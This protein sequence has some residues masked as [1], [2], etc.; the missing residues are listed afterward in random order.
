MQAIDLKNKVEIKWLNFIEHKE[1][2]YKLR[3]TVF[4]EQQGID[5]LTESAR[6]ENAI[7]LGAYYNGQLVSA[8]CAY[9]YFPLDEICNQWQ[10]TVP[11]NMVGHFARRV[12]L[13]E[14]RGCRLAEFLA[15]I[16][17]KSIHEVIHPDFLMITLFDTHKKL[18]FYYS[19][20]GFDFLH[21]VSTTHGQLAIYATN[22]ESIHKGISKSRTLCELLSA[23]FETEIPPLY[24]FLSK[25]EQL[26]FFNIE[27][28]KQENLYLNPISFKDELPRLSAQ[29]RMLYT[30]QKPLIES[31]DFPV[32]PA[33]ML[34]LGCGPGIFLAMISNLP[35]F[36]DYHCMGMD[37][38]PEMIAYAKLSYKKITWKVG[39]IY[40]TG[41]AAESLD[42]I[43]SS[44]VMIHL[45]NPELALKE[46]YRILKKGG[47]FYIVD[48]N[49]STFEGHPKIK[50]MIRKHAQI[51]EGNRDIMNILPE[52]AEKQNFKFHKQLETLIENSGEEEKPEVSGNVFKL[53]RV[54]MWAIFSFIS[55][56]QQMK[57]YYSQAENYYF[58]TNCKISVKVQTQIYEK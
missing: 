24:E 4:Y 13:P 20:F 39:N 12:E 49:D 28:F 14:F 48:I 22:K 56:R 29:A 50:R 47:K 55:Q 43:F 17:W 3:H 54:K 23:I 57:P 8:I 21:E 35:K 6:D 41:L 34:D 38:S 40:D 7:H 11:Q 9:I 19:T 44:F 58:K 45:V 51:Y 18:S 15:A 42:V 2:I 5:Y 30:F 16:I 53:G 37:L 33:N 52:L 31:E 36:K 10:L 25:N 26:S 27:N 32:G 46:I 1:E